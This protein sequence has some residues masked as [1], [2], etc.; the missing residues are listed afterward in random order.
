MRTFGND[1]TVDDAE[2]IT[3]QSQLVL[4]NMCI[5]ETIKVCDKTLLFSKVTNSRLEF[6]WGGDKITFD[7][8]LFKIYGV[9]LSTVN[10]NK[11]SGKGFKCKNLLREIESQLVL[12]CINSNN[13]FH[14]LTDST[15][16]LNR[17]SAR[18]GK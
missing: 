14:E 15:K 9:L 4:A 6:V 2:D 1:K 7:H 8:N 10:P 3:V 5:G 17:D 18:I 13:P 16:V 12:D 11:K